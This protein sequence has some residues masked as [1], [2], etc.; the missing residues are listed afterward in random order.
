MKKL[1]EL[2]DDEID[3]LLLGLFNGGP[4]QTNAHVKA[5]ALE[6]LSIEDLRRMRSKNHPDKWPNADLETYRAVVKELDHR[7]LKKQTR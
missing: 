7:R 2:S 1:N 6:S 3:A 5:Q 4:R